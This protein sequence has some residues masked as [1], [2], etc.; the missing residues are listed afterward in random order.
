MS[1]AFRVVRRWVFSLESY[2]ALGL[3]VIVMLAAIFAAFANRMDRVFS[4]T[5]LPFALF[6]DL[7]AIARTPWTWVFIPVSTVLIAVFVLYRHSENRKLQI[8]ARMA[9]IMISFLLMMLVYKAVNFYISVFNP[10]DRDFALQHIDKVL[11]FGKMPSQWLEPIINP[12]LNWWMGLSYLSWFVLVYTTVVVLFF[13]SEQA[14]REYAFT[15]LLTFYLGY[16]VYAFVP[17]IGPIFTVHYS[18]AIGGIPQ[19]LVMGQTLLS[20]DCFPSL[21][22]GLS[23][24]M[25]ISVWRHHRAW[26][27]LYIPMAVCI[28]FSTLYLRVHYGFDLIAGAALA[29]VTTQLGPL[30]VCDWERLRSPFSQASIHLNGSAIATSKS[31]SSMA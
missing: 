3:V 11:F 8:I 6:D 26:S 9:R 20:R 18:K 4:I 2:E 29:I 17:A 24:V 28:I 27:W 10:F 15:A 21:H 19:M 25:V 30:M 16:T 5:G 31:R 22:T 23:L 7:A 12:F 1:T 13:K 14:L